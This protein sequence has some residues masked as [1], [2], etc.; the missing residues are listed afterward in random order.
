MTT[1]NHMYTIAF[2]IGDSNHPKGEDLT[3][4]DYRAALLRRINSIDSE[5]DSAWEEALGYPDDTYEE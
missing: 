5:G 4:N 1:Y 3:A 2:S